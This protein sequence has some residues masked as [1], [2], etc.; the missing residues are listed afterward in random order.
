MKIS[1]L[2]QPYRRM[3]EY[4]SDQYCSRRSDLNLI[5]SFEWKY[6]DLKFWDA[7]NDGYH[8]VIT[9]NIK[10]FFPP[11][12]VFSEEE[13]QIKCTFKEMLENQKKL[14][15]KKLKKDFN[16]AEL[17]D[18]CEFSEPMELE[19]WNND[20]CKVIRLISG[21]FLGLYLVKN[22]NERQVYSYLFAQLPT[23]KV[24][25]SQFKIGDVVEVE[26]QNI[27][28]VG[29]F[30]SVDEESNL[31]FLSQTNSFIITSD[32]K[33]NEIKSITKLK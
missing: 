19:V 11:D 1:D 21:K 16:F 6:T 26:N 15:T 10:A 24:D 13:K 4:L 14:I 30:E 23:P 12:F 31:L 7:V 32:F 27:N 28:Y 29:Y 5:Q 8:P 17:Q 22:P 33:I 25:F 18:T 2:K 20:D 9:K 3:A